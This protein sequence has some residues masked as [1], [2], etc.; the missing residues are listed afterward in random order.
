MSKFPMVYSGDTLSFFIDGVPY[1]ADASMPTYEAVKAELKSDDPDADELI[2]LVQPAQT[3]ADAVTKAEADYLPKGTVS[4]TM[5]SVSFNGEVIH[6]VLVDRILGMLAEGFDIMPMVRFLENLYTNPAD[7]AR[8]ELY[9][10]LETS[11]LPITED[12]HF[13]AYKNV[14]AN[15]TSIHDGRTDNTPG[16]VVSMPRNAV[17]DDRN[18]TC[19]AGLHFCSASYLPSFSYH[20]NG[21]TVLLKINPADVVS[22]PS[23]YGNAKGR[24]WKYEVLSVVEIDPQ[25]Y[26][27]PTLVSADATPI[28]QPVPGFDP[29]SQIAKD[30]F[31]A[32]NKIGLG[33][34]ED[35]LDWAYDR[36]IDGDMEPEVLESFNDLTADQ[37]AFLLDEAE[38]EVAEL[39]AQRARDEITLTGPGLRAQEVARKIKI[40][41]IKSLGVIDL[42]RR[43]AREGYKGAWK[44]P[45][46]HEL[47]DFLISKL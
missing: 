34:R 27:W 43:A 5:N 9:L 24:A 47:Q 8:D 1:Q 37:V 44:G 14:R 3:I 45:R 25:S 11:N 28:D 31:E 6:G 12:G 22:I 29:G 38:S 26:A 30:L 42:R 33:C 19:S 16:K 15:F 10:W 40:D 13:L 7:F 23:D 2:R 46:A 18:R 35:R 20:S 4:V 17:D 36:L 39:G 41:E 21:H 32:C